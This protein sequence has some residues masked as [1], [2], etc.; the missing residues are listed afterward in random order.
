MAAQNVDI[1]TLGFGWTGSFLA[2]YIRDHTSL[3][4]ASTTRDGKDG[5]IEWTWDEIAEGGAQFEGLPTAKTLVIVFPIKGV[6]GSRRLVEGYESIHGP[7]R[8]IQLGSSGIFDV[9]KLLSF[10]L[11]TD[12]IRKGRTNCW[13]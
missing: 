13:R 5:S 3:T 6:G 11:V 7:V 12:W 10:Y 1:L 8:I 4:L 9:R 2:P